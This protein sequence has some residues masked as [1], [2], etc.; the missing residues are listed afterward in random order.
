MKEIRSEIDI[1]APAA[2][3]WE[4]LTDFSSYP[5]WNPFIKSIEGETREDAK[6][7]V[8]LE[9]PGR[10]AMTF[11]PTVQTSDPP[12]EF[13][14]LGRLLLPR[15]F[16]GEHIFELETT[17]EGRTRLL[18]R[19]EFRGVL[20]SPLL[21]WVGKNTQQGFDDMNAALKER[22]EAAAD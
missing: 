14:W 13:R 6:L 5:E 15:I 7:T 18:Q 11:K 2:R 21:R 9:P 3:V 4:V 16:D 17:D 20:V 8:R 19:E 1:D 10:R 22:A 12:K